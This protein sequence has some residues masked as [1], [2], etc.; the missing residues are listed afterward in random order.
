MLYQKHREGEQGNPFCAGPTALI[1]K[2]LWVSPGS[3]ATSEHRDRP[4]V[5]TTQVCMRPRRHV[6]T[7]V[8]ACACAQVRVL[9]HRWVCTGLF[10]SRFPN[11][12]TGSEGLGPL[13]S[14][15]DARA[16]P[17]GSF[18]VSVGTRRLHF[19]FS[20]EGASAPFT[21]AQG[22][23]PPLALRCG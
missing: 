6:H 7:G 20:P 18:F 22:A 17:C 19:L 15:R 21:P 16:H 3:R 13:S 1:P 23:S 2:R 9:V 14:G 11:R 4:P 10:R 12:R 5:G 8:Q